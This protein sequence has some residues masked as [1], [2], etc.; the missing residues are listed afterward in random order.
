MK[1]LFILL[2][3]LA[4]NFSICAEV[5]KFTAYEFS[6]KTHDE[7]SNYWTDWSRWE[8]CNILV[9]VNFDA[10]RINIYSST[11]QEFDIIQ[12]YDIYTDNDGDTVLKHECVDA[13]GVRCTVRIIIRQD[14]TK[15]L[16]CDY[17]NVMYVYNM[18]NK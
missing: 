3:L 4:I 16:Y 10:N 18:Y 13:D 7:Y 15:Q 1:K 6:Y 14:G 11:P 5:T 12:Y 17:S 9:V 8:K 2:S